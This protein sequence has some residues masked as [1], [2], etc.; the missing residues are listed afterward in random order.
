M[1]IV[2]IPAYN[3]EKAI[4]K[5]IV[6]AQNFVDKV[7]VCD[8]GS[9]DSTGLIAERLGA[10]VIKHVRN[11]GYG[12]A[13]RSLF[14]KA[15]KL[16]ASIVV[17]LDADGQH[18]PNQIP[19]IIKPILDKKADITIGSRFMKI[20]EGE[21]S[22]FRKIAIKT[23]NKI[24]GS[25]GV[26]I[27]DTQS[28]FRAYNRISI[29]KITPSEQGMGVS[30]EILLKAKD[31]GLKIAEIAIAI[32]YEGIRKSSQNPIFHFIDVLGG[33]IKHLSIRHPLLFYGIPGFVFLGIGIFSGLIT[34]RFYMTERYFSIPFALLA[35]VFTISGLLLLFA[36]IILFTVISIVRKYG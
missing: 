24:S 18:D 22:R 19:T 16:R 1:I 36:G 25:G 11:M 3:E 35:T 33:T 28:G 10:I 7:V 30:T 8:D 34:V 32:K 20:R 31:L 15:R 2:C 9:D 14:L 5:I 4:G 12:S 21:I 23:I 13:I 26:K 17:T 27:A 6:Q 29:K